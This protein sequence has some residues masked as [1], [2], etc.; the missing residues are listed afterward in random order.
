MNCMY[1]D[2]NELPTSVAMNSLSSVGIFAWRDIVIIEVGRHKNKNTRS[3]HEPLISW[4][5]PPLPD[6]VLSCARL[7][8]AP[9]QCWVY[10]VSGCY[11]ETKRI[12]EFEKRA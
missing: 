6:D 7:F 5:I 1:Q 8:F 4:H 2:V 11:M 12:S 3:I 10:S 9:P